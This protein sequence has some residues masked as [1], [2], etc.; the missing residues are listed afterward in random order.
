M[1]KRLE[2]LFC[3]ESLR[4][5]GQFSLEKERLRAVLINVY[6][7]LKEGCKEGRARLFSVMSSDENR[8]NGHKHTQEALSDDQAGGLA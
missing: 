2:H 3:E 1:K 8:D 5:L 7:Y 6:K 4:E